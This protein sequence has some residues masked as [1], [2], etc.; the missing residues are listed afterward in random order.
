MSGRVV[1]VSLMLAAAAPPGFAQQ[2]TVV[3]PA[4]A[5][6]QTRPCPPLCLPQPCPPG[7]PSTSPTSPSPATPSQTAS[8]D[9]NAP[10][11]PDQFRGR[12]RSRHS[13][14]R[15]VQSQYV[16]RHDRDLRSENG[17][18]ARPV[19]GYPDHDVY[20]HY[21]DQH[22]DQ[23]DLRSTHD[24]DHNDNATH[25]QYDFRQA[26]GENGRPGNTPYLRIQRLQDHR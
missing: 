25:S 11:T 4:A 21:H 14:Q 6:N 26:T 17:A 1:L 12:H 19:P 5:S 8:P 18:S 16:R 24:D 13:A 9:T 7:T 10:A 3:L 2:N 23:P 15:H 20:G 22:L